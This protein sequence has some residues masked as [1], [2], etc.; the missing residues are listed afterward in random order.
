MKKMRF[1]Y[2]HAGVTHPEPD[3]ALD[4]DSLL[5]KMTIMD[6]SGRIVVT[7]SPEEFVYL[8]NYIQFDAAHHAYDLGITPYEW[9]TKKVNLP[10]R[11]ARWVLDTNVDEI[12]LPSDASLLPEP[13]SQ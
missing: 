13:F 9:M 1:N 11:V 12:P 5:P 10:P 8:L 6:V 3:D 4:G 2:Q 7:F